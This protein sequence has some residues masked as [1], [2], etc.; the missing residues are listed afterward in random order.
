MS[1]PPIVSPLF[2]A[3]SLD[4]WLLTHYE[5][6]MGDAIMILFECEK[7]HFLLVIRQLCCMFSDLK[8]VAQYKTYKSWRLLKNE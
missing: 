8:I 5:Q 3:F 7:T 1:V 6:K 4:A 2:E